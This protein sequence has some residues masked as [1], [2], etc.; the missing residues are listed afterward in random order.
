MAAAAVLPAPMEEM[1]VA[2]G[3]YA[4]YSGVIREGWYLDGYKR[5][6]FLGWV[7]LPVTT[8]SVQIFLS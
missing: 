2:A 8:R 6:R 4:N 7:R 5:V 1:T 3:N